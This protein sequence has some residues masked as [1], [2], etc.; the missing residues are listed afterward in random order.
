M[1]NFDKSRRQIFRQKWLKFASS[2]A[3]AGE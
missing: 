3:D 2:L 1:S